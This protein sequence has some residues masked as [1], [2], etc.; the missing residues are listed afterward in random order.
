LTRDQVI[1]AVVS[2]TGLPLLSV[3]PSSS[4]SM[5]AMSFQL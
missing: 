1:L 4:L 2:V 5:A 3:R